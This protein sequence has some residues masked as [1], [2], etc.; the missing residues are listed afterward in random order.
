MEIT[1]KYFCKICGEN[2]ELLK[3]NKYLV[4]FKKIEGIIVTMKNYECFDCPKCGC[5]NILNIREG[6]ELKGSD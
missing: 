2:F 5:Q 1:K 4:E 6:K 3:G